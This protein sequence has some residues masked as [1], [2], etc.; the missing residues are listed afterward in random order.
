MRRIYAAPAGVRRDCSVRV[1][2]R[3]RRAR[4]PGCPSARPLGQC[5]RNC[6][7]HCTGL[8]LRGS[9]ASLARRRVARPKRRAHGA[10]A[11][12]EPTRA[13]RAQ[14]TA[15]TARRDA[16]RVHTA[17]RQRR[18]E[19]GVH[20]ASPVQCCRQ[21]RQH[22]PSG[23]PKDIGPSRSVSAG[24]VFGPGLAASSEIR[25]ASRRHRRFS[26]A[27]T[28]AARE[29]RGIRDGH[30]RPCHSAPYTSCRMSRHTCRPPRARACRTTRR[31][32]DR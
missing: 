7:Q 12:R 28:I 31:S 16:V 19:P 8:A 11:W 29:S 15:G 9:P 25:D 6:R 30:S 17:W 27:P 13:A 21:F 32:S 4:E 20:R 26:S 18:G 22:W 3:A 24:S 10:S 2:L 14:A 23:R 1:R 5:C